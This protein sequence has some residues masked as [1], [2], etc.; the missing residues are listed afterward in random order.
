MS[1]SRTELSYASGVAELPLLGRTIGADLSRTIARFGERE[2][3][4]DVPSGRRWTYEELGRAVDEVALGLLAKGVGKGDRVGIWSP[5]C[6]EWVLVQ[7][8]TARIGAILV[9]VN[10]A[11]R[12]HELG[13][14]LRQSG[15][16]VLVS[17]THH[18]T[19][20]YRRMIEQVRGESPALRDVV[21]IGDPT[22]GGLL[23]A[24]AAV[25]QA[26]LAECEAG[27]TA[28]D[29]VNIQYTSGTT[30]FPKGATLSHHNI[31]NNGFWVGET[32]G[33]TADDRVCLPVP[34]YHCFGM[35]MGNLGATS[36]GACIV[37]PG[38][39][40][41][42]ADTLRAVQDERCTSLYGVPTMF[43]AELNHP[44]FA[45]YDLTSLRTG[46]MAGSPCPEEVMKRVVAEM[47]MA[48]VSICYGMTETSPVST[49]TRRDDD[50]E[51]RTATVGRV[52]P[53]IEVKVLDPATGGTVP[54]GTPGELCTRGYSVM[55]GYWEEP[56][57]TAEV[58]DA[59]R[60][61]HTGDLAV[62]NDDG[63]VRIVGRIKDMIIRGGENVYPR[64]IEEFLYT[65]P[66]IADVQVVGVPDEKYGEEIAACVILR[67]PAD[68]LTRDEL[69]R[70][71]RSRLA[72][73]KVPRYL[74]IV[75]AFP[76]TVSGKV[77]KIELRERLAREQGRVS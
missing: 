36:H 6:A 40:F 56:E 21:Y 54:R 28:D 24:G 77:R 31:L 30:G 43:I 33:Y 4:V 49:Q 5:N 9:N 41:D 72:H 7:Y 59:G 14:V 48:E 17:A 46:I 35:V 53:H 52:L 16:Q 65:H 27:L 39:A 51:H 50:L 8:A 57:R 37:I 67:D 58:I 26:R 25:P 69:A 66:K 3:L 47:H 1:L 15:I 61:M 10:P 34:F 22:W 70:Y 32:V 68:P 63:Y 44:D 20:D 55:L 19:S 18:K 64:E 60:W 62:M 2:A 73:F 74:D 13:Y 76:M 42:A 75:D 29:P 45:S 38:L 12:V 23:A 11:Y 71:C